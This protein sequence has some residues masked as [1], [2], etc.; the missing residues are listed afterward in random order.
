MFFVKRVIYEYETV[1]PLLREI[2]NDIMAN[3]IFEP[4]YLVVENIK[5]DLYYHD[6]I[7]C[8]N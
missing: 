1:T 8:G 5:V 3:P 4:F 2:L 7:S 6:G